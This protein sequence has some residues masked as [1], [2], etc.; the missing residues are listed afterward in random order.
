MFLRSALIAKLDID[1]LIVSILINFQL[2]NN[3]NVTYFK[4]LESNLNE[5][6]LCLSEVFNRYFVS[7]YKYLQNHTFPF[8]CLA[9]PDGG[10]TMIPTN[11]DHL[12]ISNPVG[13]TSQTISSTKVQ[14]EAMTSNKQSKIVKFHYLY[15]YNIVKYT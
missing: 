3:N 5:N 6:D 14:H 8:I 2:L 1:Q 11:S 9:V 10:T 7:N 12:N 15:Y 13:S 4:I